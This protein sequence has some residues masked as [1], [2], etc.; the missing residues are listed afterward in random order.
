MVSCSIRFFST[1]RIIILTLNIVCACVHMSIKHVA[2]YCV[3]LVLGRTFSHIA[4][5]LLRGV[6]LDPDPDPVRIK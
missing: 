6:I 3:R 5:A 4:N 1:D 2:A